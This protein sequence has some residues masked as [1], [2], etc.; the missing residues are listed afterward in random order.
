M[1]EKIV[2]PHFASESDEADWWFEHRE[3]HDVIMAKAMVEGRTKTPTQLFAELGLKGPRVAVPLEF[4][5]LVQARDARGINADD[6]V[7]ELLHEALAKN[8]AA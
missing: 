4:E 1:T 5:D 6:Y 2:V 7:R 3:E 8:G